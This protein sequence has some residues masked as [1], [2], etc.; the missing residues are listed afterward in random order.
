VKKK[1]KIIQHLSEDTIKQV[2]LVCLQSHYRFRPGLMRSEFEKSTYLDA[3]YDVEFGEDVIADVFIA[4][5]DR[6]GELFTATVEATSHQK[7]EEV[8]YDVQTKLL[9]WDAAAVS[10]TLVSSFILLLY[11]LGDF[12]LDSLQGLLLLLLFILLTGIGILL[13][14][15][16][17]RT[18]FTA[19]DRYHYIYAVEQFKRYF[20]DEQ[21]IAIGTDVFWDETVGEEEI[22]EGSNS[23]EFLELKDQ[24]IKN[25][26]GLIEVQED[27]TPIILMTPERRYVSTFKNRLP[28]LKNYTKK[29]LKRAMAATPKAVRYQYL[30]TKRRLQRLNVRSK[31]SGKLDRFKRTYYIQMVICAIPIAM[32]SALYLL[33]AA[34]KPYETLRDDSALLPANSPSTPLALMDNDIRDLDSMDRLHVQEFTDLRYDYLSLPDDQPDYVLEKQ[35]VKRRRFFFNT[36]DFEP[37]RIVEENPDELLPVFNTQVGFFFTDQGSIR[38]S[39]SCDT[40]LRTDSA[41]YF[42]QQSIYPNRESAMLQVDTLATRGINAHLLHARCLPVSLDDYIVFLGEPMRSEEAATAQ[43][44]NFR[45]QLLQFDFTLLDFGVRAYYLDTLL[46]R[47][48]RE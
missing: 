40:Y 31:S 17:C 1:R 46:V 10:I 20:A 6:D 5:P 25:G 38:D 15:W 48:G 12:Q 44:L 13:F 26:I 9:R 36:D 16:I 39:A 42:V 43:A 27:L 29:R 41:T 47:R 45:Q 4:Y 8:C 23:P 18:W 33:D 24:C 28:A 11:W 21:W 7:K 14:E 22:V 35:E 37:E 2:A 30:R 3:R 19:L 34:E 32:L